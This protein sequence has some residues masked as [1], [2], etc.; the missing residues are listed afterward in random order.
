MAYQIGIHA[1]TFYSMTHREFM[2]AIKGY[3]EGQK[4]DNLRTARICAV[5]ANVNRNPKKKRSPF[6]ESDFMP[7]EKKKKKKQSPEDMLNTF[8]MLTKEKPQ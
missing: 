5:I 4:L 8:K 2:A 1:D 7:V 3:R 6:T